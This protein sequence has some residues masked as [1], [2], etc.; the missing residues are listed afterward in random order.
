MSGPKDRASGSE[1][2]GSVIFDLDGTLIDSAPHCTAILNLMLAERRT[3]MR[4]SVD[5]VRPHMIGGGPHMI[6]AL[7]GVRDKA[8]KST[9]AEFRDRYAATPTPP[10]CL[11]PGAR[12]ALTKLRSS[13]FRLGIWSNKPQ[14]LCEKAIDELSLDRAFDAVVGT[15]PAAPL[16]PHPAGLD[17]ALRRMGATRTKSCFVG[18]SE[19]DYVA[20]RSAGIPMIMITCGYGDYT[21]N[22]LGAH[23]AESLEEAAGLVQML[24]PA[25]SAA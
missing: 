23:L 20:A 9:L 13:G 6:S 3:A 8:L 2:R 14:R 15:G 24:L 19:S 18:D 4:L 25:R 22:W 12:E 1:V 5:Q 11:Y 16:K 21:E 7:L 17:L 10:D